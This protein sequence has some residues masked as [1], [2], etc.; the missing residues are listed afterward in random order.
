MRRTEHA[1]WVFDREA[2]LAETLGL[3]RDAERRYEEGSMPTVS[4]FPLT[5][6]P[7]LPS[8][9]PSSPRSYI[10]LFFRQN[11]FPHL[12][13]L[14]FVLPSFTSLP[15]LKINYLSYYFATSTLVPLRF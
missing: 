7:I 1:P 5:R 12:P 13:S 14:I 2:Y 15:L 6:F 11:H 4:V 8:L 3:L 9:V 10:F